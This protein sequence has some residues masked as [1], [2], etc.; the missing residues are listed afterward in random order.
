MSKMSENSRLRYLSFAIV[1]IGIIF[2]LSSCSVI[3]FKASKTDFTISIYVAEYNSGPAVDGATVT[4]LKDGQILEEKTTKSDGTV[5]FVLRGYSGP[6]DIRIRKDG[7]ANTDIRLLNI[8]SN[9]NLS[10]TLR[11]PKFAS[12]NDNEIRVNFKLY[13]SDK[14][15][16]RYSSNSSGVYELLNL[17]MIYIDAEATASKLG[18]SHMYAKLGTPPGAEYLTSPRLYSE[19]G[20]LSGEISLTAHSGKTYLFL[21]AY[22]LNDN[23]FELVIPVEIRRFSELRTYYYRVEYPSPAV[24]SY[25]LNTSTKYYTLSSEKQRT[26]LYNVIKWYTLSESTQRFVAKEPTGYNIYKSYD[27]NKFFKIT[28]LPSNVKSYIDTYNNKVRKRVWYAVSSDYS[29][30]EGPRVV[31]GSVEPLPMVKISNV[32]PTDSA[33]EVSTKPAFRWKF[34]GLEDYEGKVKY[35]YDIWIYDLTVNSGTYHYPLIEEPFFESG[36][37]EVEIRFSDYNWYNLPGN[38]LQTGKPYEWGPELVAAKWEDAENN[39][40]A[41]SV[42]CDYNFKISPVVIEP[43][44]YYLFIT[45]DK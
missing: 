30:I 7:F 38:E 45:G 34:V 13:E 16:V 43:E 22:D 40:V 14:M 42:N 39:S 31:L 23:R 37:T 44:R 2:F 15:F 33:T 27:G 36:N 9:I 21:D 12:L 4:L 11:R 29:G 25:H 35:L 5:S 24:Y 17:R 41:L 26:D 18:I 8:H 6:Y 3:P 28:T 10:T 1:A 32:E 19:S 20:R